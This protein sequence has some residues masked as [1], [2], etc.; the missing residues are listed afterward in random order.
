MRALQ[1]LVQIAYVPRTHSR[2]GEHLIIT[3]RPRYAPSVARG[4]AYAS[5]RVRAGVGGG[6]RFASRASCSDRQTE[7]LIRATVTQTHG[8]TELPT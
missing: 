4:E 5:R 1:S 7:G 3:S 2:N 6:F 8:R